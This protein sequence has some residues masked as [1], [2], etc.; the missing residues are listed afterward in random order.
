MFVCPVNC[1]MHELDQRQLSQRTVKLS[2]CETYPPPAFMSNNS[3][4]PDIIYRTVPY[5]SQTKL[6][7]SVSISYSWPHGP[8][9]GSE[10]PGEMDRTGRLPNLVVKEFT[11]RGEGNVKRASSHQTDH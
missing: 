8:R 7:H 6:P 3:Q 11:R 4:F 5:L 2:N 1:G 10:A 9:T